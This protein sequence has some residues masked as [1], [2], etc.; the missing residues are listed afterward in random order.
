MRD[1]LAAVTAP[2]PAL[3]GPWPTLGGRLSRRLLDGT[4]AAEDHPRQAYLRTLSCKLLYA[5]LKW[6][7]SGDLLATG[8][9][10]SML[11]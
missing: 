1:V 5:N 11:G 2:A 3:S 4:A 6:H 9:E 8:E 10:H 7:S